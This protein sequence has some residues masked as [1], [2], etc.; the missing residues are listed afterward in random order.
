MEG[1]LTANRYVEILETAIPD[2]LD[3]VPL[4]HVNEIYFQQDGAPA[5][6]S[7]MARLFLENNF[8]NQ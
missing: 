3:D 1:N 6:N 8:T 7:Q 2:L 5:H 4:A